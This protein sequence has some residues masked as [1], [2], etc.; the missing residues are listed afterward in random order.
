VLEWLGLKSV[1]VERREPTAPPRPPGKLGSRLGLGTP[2]TLTDAQAQRPFARPPS[3]PG[4][5]RPDA[6]YL[7]RTSVAFVYG[8]RPSYARLPETGA[9]LLVQELP[10]RVRPFI[11]KTLGSGAR[12]QRLRIGGDP[13]YFI[14]GTHGFAY[15]EGGAVAFEDARLAGNTLLVE[16]RDGM[17]LRVE[18]RLSLDRAVRIAESVG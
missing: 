9:A 1:K 8:R 14:T 5:G 17:L 16:R 12:L 18:G 15:G 3:A 4:L 10:A 13:A 6:V 7:G 11:E 2:A